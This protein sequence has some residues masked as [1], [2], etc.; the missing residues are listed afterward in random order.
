M[1]RVVKRQVGAAAGL[2]A[3]WLVASAATAEAATILTATLTNDQEVTSSLVV[4]TTD[5]GAP[6]T[7]FGS[8]VLVLSDD[9]T[10]LTYEVTVHG[11]DLTFLQSG[12]SNDDLRGAH[13]H[14]ASA[15]LNGPVIFGFAFPG[16]DINP[17]DLVITPFA[18]GVGGTLSGKWDLGEGLNTTL[19][20]QLP[21]ILAG[22][23]YIN[24]HTVQYPGGEIRGQIRVAP[25]PSLM[26]LL[27]LGGAAAL[28]RR[29]TSRSPR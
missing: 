15:G 17:N 28:A 24:I 2:F 9:E 13:I 1:K 3:G 4:P 16:S 26:V 22:L 27:T 7:S 25:E 11:I 14:S 10:T 20:A 18:S 5:A 21:S 29:R 23:T 19:T 12:D 8:A 6:R